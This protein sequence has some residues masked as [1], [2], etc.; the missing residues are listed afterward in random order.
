MDLCIELPI[1]HIFHTS[2]EIPDKKI[3]VNPRSS[4]SKPAPTPTGSDQ[5]P[6]IGNQIEPGLAHP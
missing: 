5:D 1:C 2:N 6:K 3:S 4:F